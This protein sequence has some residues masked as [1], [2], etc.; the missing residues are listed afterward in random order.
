MTVFSPS[1]GY[2]N[3]ITTRNGRMPKKMN[4]K[5]SGG[6]PAAVTPQ[7]RSREAD[8]SS[9]WSVEELEG[10]R[11]FLWPGAAYLGGGCKF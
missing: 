4:S 6:R 10:P 3:I 8:F 2:I 9:L 1:L 5:M 11:E 7:R